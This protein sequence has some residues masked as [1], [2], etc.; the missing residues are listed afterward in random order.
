MLRALRE[1]QFGF[2]PSGIGLLGIG[3]SGRIVVRHAVEDP[4]MAA[5][6]TRAGPAPDVAQADGQV[7]APWLIVPESSEAD[8]VL[9]AGVE[10]L[11]RH[12]PA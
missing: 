7:R 1:G 6:V 8:R 2:S 5:L 11:T 12:L 4:A 9:E 10:W 3:G